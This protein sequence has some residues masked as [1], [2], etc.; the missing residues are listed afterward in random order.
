MRINIING[1]GV[2]A[3]VVVGLGVAVL[4]LTDR[5]STPRRTCSNGLL[6]VVAVGDIM[7]GT[8]LAPA[9]RVAG[10]TRDLLTAS[11]VAIGSLAMTLLVQPELAEANSPVGGSQHARLFRRWGF[12]AFAR[13]NT[14]TNDFGLP[15]LEQ[16]SKILQNNKLASAGVG[17]DLAAARAPGWVQ[18]PCGAVAVIS[19]ATSTRDQDP[20]PALPTRA[21]IAGRPG[22]NP[23]RYSQRTQVDPETY[24][25]LRDSSAKIGGPPP[26]Q[27]GTLHAFGMILELGES[28]ISTTDVNLEDQAEVLAAIREAR[29]TAA[30][31]I[32]SLYSNEHGNTFDEPA[33]L[34]ENFAR[35]AVDAGAGLVIGH[36]SYG[37]R[38]V[39]IQG[40]SVVAYGLGNFIADSRLGTEP[41][42]ESSNT[43]SPTAED[44][45]PQGAILSASFRDGHVVSARLTALNLAAA[46]GLPQ[47]F[48]RL[49]DTAEIFNQIASGSA[50]RGA[51][52]NIQKGSAD[53]VPT[54]AREPS[55]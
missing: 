15:G 26:E 36:G 11:N 48:P 49:S 47:G 8:D 32:V 28:N 13:S 39:E 29:K 22:I 2:A 17:A 3:F 12:S 9:E 16:T 34:V 37:L 20:N 4:L 46:P 54:A 50:S 33:A 21:G 42:A 30:L 43:P 6:S 51:K 1:F 53:L 24:A 52:L 45:V 14:R 27:D 38:P 10:E 23:L 19:V 44:P 31:V 55:K 41:S 7:M 25:K 18:T 5:D 35:A 40:G